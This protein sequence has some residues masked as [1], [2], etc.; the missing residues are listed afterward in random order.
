M[1]KIDPWAKFPKPLQRHL[2]QR[3]HDRSISVS[4][5]NQL[6]LWIESDPQVP[7]GKWCKAFDSFI[8]CGEGSYPKTFLLPG[9][10]AF[11]EKL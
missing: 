3:M 6:R 1:P 4:D 8:L 5:L 7:I 10:P 9:Q 2:I 11:G